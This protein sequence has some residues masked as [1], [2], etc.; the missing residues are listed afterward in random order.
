M[1]SIEESVLYRIYGRGR[2][3]VFSSSDFID[4][5]EANN[6]DKALSDL[7]KK[8][9]IRRVIRGVYD[10]PKYSD[11]LKQELSSDPEQVAYA[12]ARKFKW[13]I[14]PSGETALNL[15]GLSTQVPGRFLYLSDGPNRSY[16]VG[17]TTL[18][19]KKTVL[20]EIGFKYTQSGLI[21]SALKSL[22]KERITVEVISTLKKQVQPKMHAKILKDT[23]TVTGWVYD[24]IKQI[25]S[26]DA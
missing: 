26:E 6:I 23:K 20:K 10:Y 22:G 11:L 14:E 3:C 19:F 12:L 4:E 8:G 13:R 2:G 17:Q 21:V 16:T 24:A 9:K 18:E 7:T 5:F 15:L 1:K 25:C